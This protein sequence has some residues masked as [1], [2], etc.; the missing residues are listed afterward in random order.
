MS[1]PLTEW[2]SRP[3]GDLCDPHRVITYGIVKVGDFIPGGVP[4]IRGGDIRRNRIEFND[5]K[6]VSNQVSRMFQRTILRGG[7]LVLNLIAEPGHCA[8]V[9]ETM[10][11]F[12]VTRDVAVIPLG[13]NVDHRFVNYSLQSPQVISWLSARLQG[14]VTQKINLATLRQVPVGLPPIS[15]QTAIAGVL[16]A[17]DDKIVANVRV[18]TAADSLW[19][20]LLGD[21]AL[22][23]IKRPLS[24]LARFVN[25]GAFTK[26]ATGNGR[27]VVRIAELNSGP[28]GSTIY[29]DIAV[30][31]DNLASPGNL[32]FAWSGSLT[33]ARWFRPEAIVNQHIFRGTRL[34]PKS[35]DW[36][37]CF[38]GPVCR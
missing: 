28:S 17:I 8:M 38:R 14:S 27:L 7:E 26:N 21:A 18:A 30:D 23:G 37:R 29:N 10:K 34:P 32:L 1:K 25:G 15:E 12:N 31:N 22:D 13:P 4:V 35:G 5:N 33:V 16:G 36:G 24:S 20:A 6:R 19:R 9:P 3:L 11:G 2:A